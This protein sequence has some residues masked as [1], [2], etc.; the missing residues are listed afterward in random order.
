MLKPYD[1]LENILVDIEN[2]IKSNL[3]ISILSK[4]YAISYSH[5]CRLFF[6]AFKQP[7]ASYIRSR[8]LAA[9]LDDILETDTT[10]Y[11]IAAEYGFDYEQSFIRT[12]KREFGITPGDLRKRGEII[13]I[14]PPLHLFNENKLS[15]DCVFF[16]PDIVMIPKFHI[17]GKPQQIPFKNSTDMAPQAAKQFWENENKKIHEKVNPHVYIGLTR[18]INMKEKYSEYIPSVQVENIANIPDECCGDTFETSMCARFRYIGQHHY[19]DI[20]KNVASMMYTAIMKFAQNEHSKYELL[21]DKTYFE[22]IDTKR[23]DGTY[24]QMEWYTPVTE[25]RQK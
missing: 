19:Y 23:Y 25:K 11:E 3:N 20:N 22:R 17:I 8:R 15:D 21:N 13:K 16:G 10:I 7:I 4:K 9:S 6:F 12:F 2:N 14:T 24:C 1:L 18:N 5:L